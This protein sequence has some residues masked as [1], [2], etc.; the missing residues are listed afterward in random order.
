MAQVQKY[1]EKFNDQLRLGRFE[2][3]ATLREKRD[4]IRQKLQDKLS[5]EFESHGERCPSY[6][7]CDQGSYHLGTGIKPIGGD[8]DIDQGVY[9][10]LE[11]AEF[12]DPVLLKKRIRDS[13]AGH[14][15]KVEIRGSCVTVFYQRENEDIYH[16]DLAVYRE[17]GTA[18][19]LPKIGKG[20]EH[21]EGEY[22][23][24]ETSDPSGLASW[25]FAN[26]DD[27][28]RHQLRRV[29]RY[30]KRWKDERFVAAGNAAPTGIALTV[31]AR[32]QFVAEYSDYV[33]K[34]PNDLA[35]LRR[36]V[37]N[38]AAEFVTYIDVDGAQFHRLKVTLPVQPYSDLLERM[39][40]S[41]SEAFYQKL[42]AL[43]DALADAEAS[44]DPV[45]ACNRL[46]AVFGS[47][48][49]VPDPSETAARVAPVILGSSASA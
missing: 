48:F 47:D 15:K 46:A 43:K 31:A 45:D 27:A 36:I 42:S 25:V 24:W 32:S 10:T 6:R 21:S 49:P 35:C 1:F 30:L 12:T 3:N 28:G 8:F 18:G 19:V 17:G 40:D 22:R 13:L 5:Q 41:Q 14:T 23:L 44:V 9:F 39:S 16:V 7:F 37:E 29:V 11:D 33:A 20:K 2:E 26:L 38:V 34:T 4:V